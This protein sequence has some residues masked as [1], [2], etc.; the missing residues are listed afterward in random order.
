MGLSQAFGSKLLDSTY[1][2][3]VDDNNEAFSNWSRHGNMLLL[4]HFSEPGLPV[5]RRLP[6]QSRK[7]MST[8]SAD[9]LKGFPQL[10]C[11]DNPAFTAEP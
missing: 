6:A 4:F 11:G 9:P 7:C 2:S 8:C 5:L 1:V 10:R 3:G